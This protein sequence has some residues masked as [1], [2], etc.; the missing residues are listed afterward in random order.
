MRNNIRQ[1]VRFKRVAHDLSEVV[2]VQTVAHG[3]A[4]PSGFLA[5]PAGSLEVKI[6]TKFRHGQPRV[7]SISGMPA[8]VAVTG[9]EG[10][11]D[12]IYMRAALKKL[13][14]REGTV[15]LTNPWP[16]F[17]WDLSSVKMVKP[18]TCTLRTQM[19]NVNSVPGSTWQSEPPGLRWYS[20]WYDND[21]LS[22]GKTPITTFMEQLCVADP[23][24]FSMPA[25]PLWMTRRIQDLPRPIGVV[26]PPSAR[27]EWHN[28]SRNPRMEYLQA[29][30]NERSD[31]FWV[32]VGWTKDG[33]EWPDG[34]PLTGIAKNFDHGE[35]S[36]TEVATLISIAEIVLC[37]P[38]FPLPLS[39]ALGTPV[40]CLFGGSV[41]PRCLV[42]S[43]MGKHVGYVA[44]EP[45]CACFSNDHA[46]SKIL[47]QAH[48]LSEFRRLMALP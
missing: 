8:G 28:T 18:T 5:I 44:P 1:F 34:A 32:S 46:C 45:F 37:G 12:S 20:Y 47:D 23:I 35:L 29:V 16:Q 42:D 33:Q 25:N 30:I 38:S 9:F 14:A 21:A 41:P 10:M 36:I 7:E 27:A 11:G 43:R 6:G 4:P 48:V 19:E 26:H 2:T 22:R 13:L 31:I 15:Y 39:A 17:F 3:G 24:D 40:L